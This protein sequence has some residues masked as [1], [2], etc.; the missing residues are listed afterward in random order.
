[1]TRSQFY[2]GARLATYVV[3]CSGPLAKKSSAGSN[4][5]PYCSSILFS[6]L[7]PEVELKE[8]QM[9]HLEKAVYQKL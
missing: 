4:L 3:L 7:V 8:V 6:Q 2:L 9:P 5:K 1:M